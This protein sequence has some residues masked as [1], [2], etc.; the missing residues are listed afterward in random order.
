MHEGETGGYAIGS[1]NMTTYFNV[2]TIA[3]EGKVY[4][5]SGGGGVK[6]IL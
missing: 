5:G 6:K 2:I 3:N 1:V 4:G